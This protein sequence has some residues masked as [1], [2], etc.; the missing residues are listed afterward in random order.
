VVLRNV[1]SQENFKEKFLKKYKDIS[2]SKNIILLFEEEKI[3]AGD[4]LLKILK[5]EAQCQ[6]FPL[7][8]GDKLEKWLKDEFKKRNASVEPGVIRKLIEF[9]GDD[10]WQLNNEIEKL[11]CFKAGKEIE[12]KDISLLVRPKIETDIF[13]TID[14]I[15]QKDKKKSLLLLHRHLGKGDSPLYLLSMISFQFRNI[16][17]VKDLMEKQRPYYAI[18]KTLKL[19]PFVIKKSYEQARGFSYGELKK[20]Y[21][22]IFQIDLDLKT[23]KLKPETALDMF[24][25]EI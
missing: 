25:T 21:R 13:K 18:L 7:L 15:A 14:A 23:G 8:D 22:K 12:M 5:K 10:L 9:V 3:L 17:V 1:F 24:L 19:H 4:K 11:A 6:E 20:I 2:E 16:L